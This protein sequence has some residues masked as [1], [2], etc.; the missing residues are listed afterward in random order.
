VVSLNSFPGVTQRLASISPIRWLLCAAILH[1]VTTLTIFLIG[2]FQLLPSTLDVYGIGTSFAPDGTVYRVV[3][4]E[5]AETLRH[6]GISAWFNLKAPFHCRLLSIAF[7]FPGAIVG[8]NILAAEPLHLAYYLAIL[9]L[10]YSLA[11]TLFNPCAG[12]IAAGTIAVW[13]T[14]LI[15]STQPIRDSISITLML[16]L[17]WILVFVLQRTLNWTTA[18][19]SCIAGTGLLILFWMTRGNF[20]N[21]VLVA[22]GI[23]IVLLIVRAAA[24]RKILLTNFVVVLALLAA[25]LLIPTRIQST[26]LAT[27]RPPTAVIAIPS[28]KPTSSRSMWSQMVTQIRARR[29]AFKAYTAQQSNLDTEVQFNNEWDILKYVPRAAVIGFF[30]PFPRMW[31][32]S[33][34]SGRAA[35]LISGVETLAMYL[36]YIP[37]VMC[38][39]TERRNLAVWLMSLLTIIGV[40]ALGLVVL[41]GGALYRFR[42]VFWMMVI[43]LAARMISEKFS[44][45]SPC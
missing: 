15:H 24:G 11:K 16:S 8:Y 35:R 34:T 29:G 36:L 17:L 33:G 38:V 1:L 5:L 21:V 2:H 22:C 10:V 9:F 42:Y 18:S 12:L 7:V 41:N 25:A 30:A 4:A 27:D 37:A 32:A 39:W 43:I 31:F 14:L 20:W 19:L 28:G 3:T 6:E 45:S 44:K 23:T 26:A 40:T 13:P